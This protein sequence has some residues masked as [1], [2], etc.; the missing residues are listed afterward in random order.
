MVLFVKTA[1]VIGIGVAMIL[2]VSACSATSGNSDESVTL[3]LHNLVSQESAQGQGFETFAAAVEEATDGATRVELFHSESLV[4]AAEALSATGAGTADIAFLAASHF[5]EDLP[6][7]N[8]MTNLS[9]T[10]S[11]VFPYGWLSGAAAL[12]DLQDE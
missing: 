4:P 9:A 3:R 1:K 8:W 5:P 10:T 11:P 6:I 7:N 12:A 2:P